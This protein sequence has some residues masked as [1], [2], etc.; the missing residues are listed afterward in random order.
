MGALKKWNFILWTLKEE[1]PELIY[2]NAVSKI[3]DPIKRRQQTLVNN[4]HG[5]VRER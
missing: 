5:M 2:I 1:Y 3:G 4:F